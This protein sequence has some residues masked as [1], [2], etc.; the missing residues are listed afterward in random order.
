MPLLRVDPEYRG[1]DEFFAR[2]H[3]R[4]TTPQES[5]RK[6]MKALA[7]EAKSGSQQK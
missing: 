7:A 5:G 1:P 3:C 4:W 2:L 6:V